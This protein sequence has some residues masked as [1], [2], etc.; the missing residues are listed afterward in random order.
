MI[1]NEILPPGCGSAHNNSIDPK[2]ADANGNKDEQE[3]AERR[4]CVKRV[5]H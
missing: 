4:T 1:A 3:T 2:A 5:A